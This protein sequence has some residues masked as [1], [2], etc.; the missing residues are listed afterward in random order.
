M[1]QTVKLLLV[2]D[3]PL[4]LRR[5][6]GFKLAARG[7]EIVGEAENGV[8]ALQYV[9]RLKPDIVV[10]D[11]GMPL[12]DGLELLQQLQQQPSPPKVVLLT[13]YEDF[14]KVQ[15]ALR[16][17]AGD[18]L[19]KVMLSEDEFVSALQRTAASLR[20][21]HEG[22][23]LI[24][25]ILLQEL[26]L[27]PSENGLAN[28]K[29]AGFAHDIYAIA[30]IRTALPL[31]DAC[32]EELFAA[33]EEDHQ[34]RCLPVRMSPDTWC[35]YFYSKQRENDASF[36]G[37]YSRQCGRIVGGLRGRKRIGDYVIAAGAVYHRPGDL[38]M[39]YQRAAAQCDAGFYT[40][41]WVIAREDE[42]PVFTSF[43]QER[44][45]MLLADMGNAVQRGSGADA[46]ALVS[47]W[48]HSIGTAFHPAPVQVRQ[49]AL[50][51]HTQLEAFEWE[52]LGETGQEVL[53][54]KFKL[55]AESALHASVI[56]HE[57]KQ[58]ADMLMQSRPTASASGSMR[59][60]IK[61][62]MSL[63]AANYAGIE[64]GETARQVSLSP[65]WFAALFRTA[66]GQS[67][68]D[69][70]QEVRLNQARVLLRTTDLKVYEIAEQVGIPNS[71]YF[72][73]LF[74]E[75]VGLTPLDYRKNDRM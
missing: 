45:R 63:I 75:H 9:E 14:D 20:K 50:A 49:M 66:T 64:L 38:P 71:R 52:R 35:L 68:H 47:E 23:E 24:V 30:I 44:F 33:E 32:A 69:Y 1:D 34:R 51:I 15:I 10:T 17:G 8:Q 28:L 22:T 39:A 74:S 46:G 73:R 40:P 37:W 72:S 60:E 5:I 36:Y 57:A 3:E 61:Q 55:A 13:C 43:P 53:Q 48:A 54:Q 65:S 29:Q 16:F 67:F 26:L 62:A 42:T 12:M 41:S 56:V 31:Q 4:A 6:R 21:E 19:T 18:Y 11:I 27:F 25:R 58:M 70:V 2:D 59:K 7:F